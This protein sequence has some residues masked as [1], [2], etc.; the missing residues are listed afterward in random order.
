MFIVGLLCFLLLVPGPATTSETYGDEE[1]TRL[2][3]QECSKTYPDNTALQILRAFGMGLCVKVHRHELTTAQ[4]SEIFGH[5]RQR[6][7]ERW[8]EYDA[9]T[10]QTRSM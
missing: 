9:A 6:F 4:A 8:R 7:I 10:E 1:A 5:L 2:D 3:W